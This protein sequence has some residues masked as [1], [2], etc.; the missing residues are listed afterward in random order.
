[1]RT[2][3]ELGTDNTIPQGWEDLQEPFTFEEL[4]FQ[5]G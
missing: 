2:F 4:G 5:Y 1:M 3:K